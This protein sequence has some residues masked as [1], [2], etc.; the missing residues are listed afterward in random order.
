MQ[1][2]IKNKLLSGI[3]FLILG[4]LLV[5]A[6]TASMKTFVIILGAVLLVGALVR[7]IAYFVTKKEDRVPLSLVL[8][9]A[10]AA[11]GLFFVLA[12]ELVTDILATVFGVVLILNALL[13]LVIAVRLPSGKPVATVLALLGL[14]LG[15]LIVINPKAFADFMTRFIGATLIYESV[16]CIVTMLFARKTAKSGLLDK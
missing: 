16:V 2:I 15:I 13:D 8:G 12:P 10:A 11:I 5:I 1:N 7:L 9:I 3:I 4:V 6:P 14:V